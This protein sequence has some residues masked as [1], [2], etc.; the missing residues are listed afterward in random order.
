MSKPAESRGD[1]LFLQI[2]LILLVI[3]AVIAIYPIINVTA[4][5]LSSGFMA[6]RGRVYL[7]P[8]EFNLESWKVVI[9]DV[10][11]WR[12]MFNSIYIT[13]VGTLS[14]ILFT[15]IFAYTLANRNNRIRKILGFIII[16]TM[17]FRYPIIPYFLSVRAYGLVNKLSTMIITH[18]LIVYNLI[19]MRTFFQQLPVELEESAVIDGA[20]HVTILFRIFLPLSKPVLAT[21][22]LFFA[23][24]YW[25]LFL[26][27]LLFIRSDE[28]F[29]LQTRLRA[30]LDLMNNLENTNQIG[31]QDAYSPTTVRA[32]AIMF[33]TVPIIMVYP[34]VQKYFVKGAMLGSVKG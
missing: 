4:V 27:P 21:L 2:N 5:S 24:T 13:V 30:L 15:A 3:V 12:S 26:H 16:F 34:F 19:I 20:G 28:L 1:R 17:V 32:A 7:W 29:P 14:S 11:L 9:Q 22:G 25:N 18:L 10:T 23:V 31:Q 6:D 8:R 33:A